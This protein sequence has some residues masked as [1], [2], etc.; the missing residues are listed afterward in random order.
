MRYK[1]GDKVRVKNGLVN[2]FYYGGYKFW[3]ANKCGQTVTINSVGKDYYRFDNQDIAT[4]YVTDEMLEPVCEKSHPKVD[5]CWLKELYTTPD[6]DS[7]V[8][9]KYFTGDWG[10]SKAY[11]DCGN[12]ELLDKLGIE[13]V[14][15]SKKLGR[16][17][18]FIQLKDGRTG[19]ATQAVDDVADWQIGFGQAYFKALVGKERFKKLIGW[20]EKKKRYIRGEGK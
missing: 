1:V 9:K 4:A 11:G 8:F 6:T 20:V 12:S 7:W 18:T 3:D 16:A 19:K 13:K 5:S 17:V 10:K 15:F 2:G 14:V